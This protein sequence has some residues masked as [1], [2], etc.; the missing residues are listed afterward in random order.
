MRKPAEVRGVALLIVMLILAGLLVLGQMAMLLMDR[1]TQRSGAFHRYLSGVPCAEEGL[2]LGRAWILQ[3]MAGGSSLNPMILQGPNPG[4]GT[5]PGT[6]LLADPSDPLDLVNKDLCRMPYPGPVMIGSQKVV[7]LS[8]LCRTDPGGSCTSPPCPAY[9]LDLIDDPDEITG[10][11]NPWVD[12][13]QVF[14]LRAECL[15]SG[16]TSK[17]PLDS[18]GNPTTVV[19]VAYVEVNQAGGSNCGVY[20]PGVNP[21]GCGGG[22]HD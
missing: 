22:Y 18:K 1:V 20:G 19:D 6:G 2:N 16:A 13:N 9:R 11:L 5:T 21:A 10:Q 15:E 7:G 4:G 17:G 3:A 14:I 8:G 12:Q